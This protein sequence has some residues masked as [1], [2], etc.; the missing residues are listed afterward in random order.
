MMAKHIGATLGFLLAV[1]VLHGCPIPDAQKAPVDASSSSSGSSGGL[2]GMGEAGS[3]GFGG[4]GGSSIT[5]GSNTSSSTSSSSSSSSGTGGGAGSGPTS[6]F[7]SRAF[8]CKLINNATLQD[9]TPNQLH[10]RF[11]L[12]GTELGVP[13]VVGSSLYLFFG[14]TQG[15]KV[16]WGFGEDPDSVAK[17]PFAS[18]VAD[19]TTLCKNL[20]FY[21]TPDNP[22]VANMADPTIQ[23]DFAGVY[24]TPPMGQNIS[25]YIGQP[26][27]PMF[28]NIPGT[29]EAPTGALAQAGKVFL[30]YAGL[31]ETVPTTRATLGYLAKWDPATNVPNFQILRPIDSLSNG[32]LG[33]H[34]IQV[35]PVDDGVHTYLFGTGNYRHSGVHLA[36]LGSASLEA[37]GGEELF[38]SASQSWKLAASMTATERQNLKPLFEVDG[39]GELSVR[40]IDSAGLYIALYQQQFYDAMGK[41]NDARVIFRFALAPEGPWSAPLTII[42]SNDPAFQSAHCCGSTCPGAQITHCNIGW[43]YGTYMLPSATAT[44]VAGGSFDLQLPFLVSTWDPYNVVLFTTSVH[45]VP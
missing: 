8:L 1:F 13:V 9:P 14:D 40:R 6:S 21:I 39:V 17:I 43:L 38:D 2:G 15:Y 42:D 3:G 36:R 41:I 26:A 18:V 22:S 4:M 20:D 30:F 11:N 44:P 16:I 28:P 25:S 45:V 34:F 31:V 29:F 7:T 10:T 12:M 33:G 19:P 5:S 24:M 27:N 35:A 37:G 23:R 32:A